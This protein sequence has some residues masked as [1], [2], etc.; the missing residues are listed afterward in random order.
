TVP[1]AGTAPAVKLVEGHAEGE[2]S[3]RVVIVPVTSVNTADYQVTGAELK[4]RVGETVPRK[5]ELTNAGPA[6][7]MATLG[8]PTV[9]VMIMLPAG[10]SVVKTP[11]F[12]KPTG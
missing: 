1:V 8:D 9:R 12:C 11:G 3:P 7:I 6:W 5:G 10:T 4:G 2:G